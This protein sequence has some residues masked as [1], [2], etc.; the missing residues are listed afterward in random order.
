MPVSIFKRGKTG[1]EQLDI[2]EVHNIWGLLRD[3]YISIET[4]QMFQNFIHDRDFYILLDTFL[5][6][7]KKQVEALMHHPEPGQIKGDELQ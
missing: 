6:H 7:F 1:K 3:R 2:Q 4:I 5:G